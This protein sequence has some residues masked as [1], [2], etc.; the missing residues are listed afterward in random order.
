M[1]GGPRGLWAHGV[2]GDE[3]FV[4]G[5]VAAGGGAGGSVLGHCGALSREVRV[6]RVRRG[7]IFTFNSIDWLGSKQVNVFLGPELMLVWV[8]SAN[9]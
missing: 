7:C 1:L 6:G 4:E 3:F 2:V 5:V 8:Y 9:R